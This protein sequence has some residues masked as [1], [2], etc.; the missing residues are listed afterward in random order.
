MT[1][2]AKLGIAAVA[3]VAA[4]GLPLL[5]SWSRAAEAASGARRY[6]STCVTDDLA[7][8]AQSPV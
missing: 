4:I 2:R 1:N 3:A 6:R 5:V 7:E 8:C